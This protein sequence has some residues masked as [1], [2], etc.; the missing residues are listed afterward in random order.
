MKNKKKVY[1]A[2]HSGMVGSAITRLLSER[3][4]VE[5]LVKTRNELDLTS[6]QSVT[7]FF[8]NNQIDEVYL[9]AAKVGGIKANSNFPAEFIYENLTIQSNVIHAAHCANIQKLLFLGSSCIYP[10]FASQPIVESSLLAG[11]LE[12]TNEPYAIA[13]IAGIK[14]CE[15]YNRQ[16]GR[17]YRAIM[18][19]NLYGRND[20]FHPYTSHVIPGLIRRFH[21]SKLNDA[22]E[23]VVWGTGN[24]KREF[25]YVDDMADASVF[26]M[27]LSSTI[28]DETTESGVSHINVGTGIDYTVSDLAKKISDVVGYK[29]KIIFDPS[30]PDGVP[31]KLLD[32][33]RLTSLGWRSSM[34]L[35]DGLRAT[36]EWFLANQGRFRG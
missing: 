11:K 13:K 23:V 15:G 30:K 35:E 14:M 29:G 27:E 17:D 34:E 21:D 31:R 9:A 16:Y 26:L 2:G 6:Q 12:E 4:D 32:I 25:L 7:R 18:P 36:Y 3:E 19:T 22:P 8:S 24:P 5:L 1:V 28:Y 33:H 20:N 10:K